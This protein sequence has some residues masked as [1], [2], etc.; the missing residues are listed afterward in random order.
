VPGKR[1]QDAATERRGCQT[2]R[3]C[4][5]TRFRSILQ[6]SRHDSHAIHR[7]LPPLPPDQPSDRP[8]REY[9]IRLRRSAGSG[10][11]IAKTFID[12][13]K[14]PRTRERGFY[15]LHPLQTSTHLRTSFPHAAQ[16]WHH[17][18]MVS[19]GNS[20]WSPTSIAW[21]RSRPQQEI[22]ANMGVSRRALVG[23]LNGTINPSK[24][25]LI[26]AELLSRQSA[27]EWPLR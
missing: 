13:N 4:M 3:A 6:P 23:W 21:L 17:F 9:A 25:V 16:V 19:A 27:G 2:P 10:Q 22:A 18:V 7:S 5:V 26:L 1:C 20:K 11:Q 8:I 15:A 24:T 12:I 14:S